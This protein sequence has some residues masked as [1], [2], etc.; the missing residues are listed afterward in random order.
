MSVGVGFILRLRVNERCVC[1]TSVI[2]VRSAPVN[3]AFVLFLLC[4]ALHPVLGFLTGLNIVGFDGSHH[5]KS[6]HFVLFIRE[7]FSEPV[8]KCQDDSTKL[9]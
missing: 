1:D 3:Q 5:N 8:G 6:F 9:C 4:S 2:L 7:Q